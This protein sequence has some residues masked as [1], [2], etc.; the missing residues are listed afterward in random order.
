MAQPPKSGLVRGHDKPIHGGC[1]I[2]FPGGVNAYVNM[3][4]MDPMGMGHRKIFHLE[5]I[6]V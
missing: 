3:P 5:N 6:Y 2:Y 4:Y 1:A